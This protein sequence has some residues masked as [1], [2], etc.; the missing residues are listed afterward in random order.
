[1]FTTL[2]RQYN[3]DQV[4]DLED[5]LIGNKMSETFSDIGRLVSR[6]LKFRP[7][8]IVDNNDNTLYTIQVRPS[9]SIQTVNQNN[10]IQIDYSVFVYNEDNTWHLD[11]Q[12]VS[13]SYLFPELKQS[14]YKGDSYRE[15]D[16][17]YEYHFDDGDTYIAVPSANPVERLDE[18]LVF[19]NIK[20]TRDL[21]P[22]KWLLETENNEY[23]YLRERSGSIKLIS[24]AGNGDVVFK[25]YIGGEHPGTKLED[26]EVID[27]ITSVEYINIVDNPE[28]S[29]PEEAYDQHWGEKEREFNYDDIDTE[30]LIDNS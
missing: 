20:M 9:D 15:R 8:R 26:N 27:F 13:D 10:P 17:D 2:T 12:Q 25:A 6:S 30:K 5:M 16:S 7:Y 23:Y 4:R 19:T 3:D 21:L 24:D 14:F 28:N 29:V 1:M 22:R 18:E 11:N